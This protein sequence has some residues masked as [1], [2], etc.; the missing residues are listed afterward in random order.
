[1][2]LSIVKRMD[3]YAWV[4]VFASMYAH[5]TENVH[6]RDQRLRFSKC[7]RRWNDV[8]TS[9]TLNFFSHFQMKWSIDSFGSAIKQKKFFCFFFFRHILG[10][11]RRFW[12]DF[13]LR[14]RICIL[15]SGFRKMLFVVNLLLALMEQISWQNAIAA[16]AISNG[17]FFLLL[18][19]LLFALMLCKSMRSHKPRWFFVMIDKI[20]KYG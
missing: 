16:K 2:K 3:E 8:Q 18:L 9:K 4:C 15:S 6:S 19:L 13:V 10:R 1:M 12:V 7:A 17:V 14:S 11:N 5:W 20:P